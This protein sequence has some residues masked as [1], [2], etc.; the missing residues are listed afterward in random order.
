MGEGEGRG[1]EGVGE[2]E[3]RGREEVGEGGGREGVGGERWWGEGGG[4]IRRS[5]LQRINSS[6][7]VRS[8][9]QQ[10]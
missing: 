7:T 4:V 5:S 6:K 2:G 10:V 8:R 9:M 3:G 1:R